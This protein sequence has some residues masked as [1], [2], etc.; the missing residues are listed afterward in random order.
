MSDNRTK[1]RLLQKQVWRKG[2]VSIR[3][4][5]P[6]GFTFTP[7]QFVRLGL[8]IEAN[9]KTEY[10]A[11]G[12][13]LASVPSDP[14]L[15]FFIVEVPNGLVSPRLCALEAGSELWL[16]TD[17][18]GSLLPDRLPASQNLW[19]LSTGTGLAPFISILRQESVWEKWPTVVLVHSVRLA[20]DLAYT[21]LIQK[22][23]DDSSLGGGSG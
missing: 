10:A 7:G 6:E 22:I 8:D 11:R 1:V 4:T 18:W 17:L 21:Q 15:E 9:G 12:Y 23:K 20:E 5:K 14:F 3:V 2:L 13:S 16:E 19:C